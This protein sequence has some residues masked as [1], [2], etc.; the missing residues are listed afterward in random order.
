MRLTLDIISRSLY[1]F[2]ALQFGRLKTLK[3][4]KTFSFN[5]FVIRM[6]AHLI[7]SHFSN[8]FLGFCQLYYKRGF[9]SK[10]QNSNMLSS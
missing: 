4:A 3:K 6:S 1:N 9:R 2:R 5:F 8:S 7:P 10:V